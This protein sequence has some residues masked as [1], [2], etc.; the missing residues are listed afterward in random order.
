[1]VWHA[2]HRL[3]LRF[4]TPANVLLRRAQIILMLVA[5]VPTVLMTGVGIIL[6]VTRS[7]SVALVSG[8][9]VVAFTTSSLTGFILGS[10]FVG[11]G[12]SLAKVQND[13]L[14]SVSH[15]LTTPITSVRM[16]IDTLRADRVTDPVERKKCLDVI[17]R[18]MARLEALV[19]KLIAL[20]RLESGR[21][22]F[23]HLPM[24]LEDLVGDA[25]D[26]FEVI[27]LGS[28]V[29]LTVDIDK[30][31]VVVGDR[32]SLGQVLVNLLANAFKYTRPDD[33][34]ISLTAKP[35][36]RHVEIV[37]ADNGPG[38]P[39]TERQRIFQEFERGSAASSG[40]VPG[41]GLGLAIVRGIVRAHDG[42]IEVESSEKG[43]RF[44][45]LLPQQKKVAT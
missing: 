10:I 34:Q 19:S 29:D 39:E 15:E 36:G 14:S 18:E 24:R 33:K 7:A 27:H 25:L 35:L 13:F 8:I 16:Y 1:M 30:E 42:R 23:E 41:S 37:V 38:I 26:A 31:A 21:A 4:R 17:D 45:I 11:R 3:Q 28:T 9:L 2:H 44:R 40:R 32:A 5:L 20:S 6:L 22:P 12:A 43:A